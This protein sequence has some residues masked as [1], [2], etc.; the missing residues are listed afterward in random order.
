MTSEQAVV[1]PLCV[2]RGQKVLVMTHILLVER[3]SSEDGEE[4]E[5]ENI[6]ASVYGVFL[7]AVKVSEHNTAQWDMYS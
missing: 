6:I 7:H 4:E 1:G 5:E 3:S 2:M